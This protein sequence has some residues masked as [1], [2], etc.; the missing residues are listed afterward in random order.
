MRTLKVLVD[1]HVTRK[2]LICHRLLVVFARQ[3]KVDTVLLNKFAK[4]A[5]ETPKNVLDFLRNPGR[6]SE[7]LK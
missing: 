4:L 3:I 6:S 5:I 1:L 7:S 2:R